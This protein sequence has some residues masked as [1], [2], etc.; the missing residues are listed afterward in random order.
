[1]MASKNKNTEASTD[2]AENTKGKLN[3]SVI[4]HYKKY[5]N[6]KSNIKAFLVMGTRFDIEDKYEIIDSGMNFIRE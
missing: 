6:T 4:E 2:A 1:M 5:R 3:P